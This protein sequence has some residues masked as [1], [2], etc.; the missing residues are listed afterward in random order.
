[1]TAPVPADGGA[2]TGGLGEE[3]RAA[4]LLAMERVT[5][6]EDNPPP[7]RL[8]YAA[9]VVLDQFI[10]AALDRARA[11]G[12][13]EERERCAKEL[14]AFIHPSR[15]QQYID[16]ERLYALAGR[17]SAYDDELAGWSGT[18]GDHPTSETDS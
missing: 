9:L 13:A 10:V 5:E 18:H 8:A 11:E 12:A 14:R 6:R 7:G 3:A 16:R 2:A 17:W 4:L 1:M 15:E